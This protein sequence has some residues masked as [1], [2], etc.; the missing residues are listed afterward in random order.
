MTIHTG[1]TIADQVEAKNIMNP[2]SFT[3]DEPQSARS[4]LWIKFVYIIYITIQS[5]EVGE[6]NLNS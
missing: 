1:V 5:L 4:R 6:V 3:N 2:L